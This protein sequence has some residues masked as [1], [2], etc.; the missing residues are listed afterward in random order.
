VQPGTAAH[1]RQQAQPSDGLQH[2]VMQDHITPKISG[3]VL[4]TT[5]S[6][7]LPPPSLPVPRIP[8]ICRLCSPLCCGCSPAAM[9]SR[10][11]ARSLEDTLPAARMDLGAAALAAGA[12][13]APAA[14]PA[15]GAASHAGAR[16]TARGDS[17]MS[18]AA[19]CSGSAGGGRAAVSCA[20]AAPLLPAAALPAEGKRPLSLCLLPA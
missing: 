8:C 15:T 19:A 5:N 9:R 17:V 18:S 7:H 14:A 6:D 13:S 2:T 1:C 10:S 3:R 4:I 20:V 11:L 16:S 12:G